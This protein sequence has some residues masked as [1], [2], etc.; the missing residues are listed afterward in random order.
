LSVVVGDK[1]SEAKVSIKDYVFGMGKA[2]PLLFRCDDFGIRFHTNN[3]R[4]RC[5]TRLVKIFVCF[6]AFPKVT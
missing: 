2:Q 6:V 3:F 4:D 1:S 5:F